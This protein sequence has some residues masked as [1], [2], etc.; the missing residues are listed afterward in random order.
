MKA[1]KTLWS[2]C[3]SLLMGV[4]LFTACSEDNPVVEPTLSISKT[5]ISATVQGGTFTIAVTSNTNWTAESSNKTVAVVTPES[6]T[7]NGNVTVNVLA[8]TTSEARTATITIKAGDL[9]ESVAVTQEPNTG[10]KVLSVAP[11][12]ISGSYTAGNYSIAVTSNTDW[13]V[14]SSGAWATISPASGSNNGTITVVLAANEGAVRSATITVTA[15]D[16]SG[17]T[18]ITQAGA[19]GVSSLKEVASLP[20]IDEG[21]YG[22][23]ATFADPYDRTYNVIV[24]K[25]TLAEAGLLNVYDPVAGTKIFYNIYN[26]SDLSDIVA[27]ATADSVAKLNLAAGVYYIAS[28][29]NM[30]WAPELTDLNFNYETHIEFTKAPVSHDVTTFPYDD[31]G[32]YSE[33]KEFVASCYGGDNLFIRYNITVPEEG[34]LTFTANLGLWLTNDLTTAASCVWLLDKGN[35]SNET[36]HLMPGEYIALLRAGAVDD[37]TI[38]IG[39]TPR[40]I[41]A[42]DPDGELIAGVLWAKCNSSYAAGAS[43]FA[44]TPDGGDAL[45]Q[46]G[47]LEPVGP[48]NWS[49]PAASDYTDRS[50]MNNP[51]VVACPTG[52][53]L[54]KN[55]E[56]SALIAAGSSW[57]AKG[58]RGNTAYAGRFFG[59]NHA[60]AQVGDA[61]AIFIPAVG[62]IPNNATTGYPNWSA[63]EAAKTGVDAEAHVTSATIQGSDGPYWMVVKDAAPALTESWA[64]PWRAQSIR[65]VKNID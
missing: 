23:Q 15:A 13:T 20:Y 51:P 19:P 2:V 28:I 47:R 33:V 43:T 31:A 6:G 55:A 10:Q 22:E 46:F 56:F 49:T 24:Y 12:S 60:T 45:F 17:K 11:T 64:R 3:A 27:E 61:G 35:P 29:S 57:A 5:P 48:T 41:T 62:Y 25:V 8:N 36:I 40:E 42:D 14:A 1:N 58:T 9:S 38:T 63:A 50:W 21:N 4:A 34:D 39:F 18:T 59:P 65:C 53:R 54:P 32:L 44:A 37:Y 7:N 30:E 16:L 26:D 52:W